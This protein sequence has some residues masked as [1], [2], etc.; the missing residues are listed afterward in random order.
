MSVEDIYKQAVDKLL[1]TKEATFKLSGYIGP[2]ELT[3][4]QKLKKHLPLAQ[5]ACKK[6][7]DCGGGSKTTAHLVYQ[8]LVDDSGT[9]SVSGDNSSVLEEEDSRNKKDIKAVANANTT[10]SSKKSSVLT[11]SSSKSN[12]NGSVLRENVDCELRRS[13]QKSSIIKE[14]LKSPY[15]GVVGSRN[16]AVKTPGRSSSE[17]NFVMASRVKRH[18]VFDC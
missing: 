1:K 14:H 18:I 12:M 2:N 11:N 8:E 15:F 17:S 10:N 5:N 7:S 16:S 13:A 6:L 4:A 3:E 9:N